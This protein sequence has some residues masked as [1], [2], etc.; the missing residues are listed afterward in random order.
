MV[1]VLI[2]RKETLLKEFVMIAFFSL[3]FA[4]VIYFANSFYIF[5]YLNE[6]EIALS[7][8]DLL[9]LEGLLVMIFGGF[10]LFI[11]GSSGA[12]ARDFPITRYEYKFEIRSTFT[13]NIMR[14]GVIL[15]STGAIL[16]VLCFM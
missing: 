2:M 8:R 16:I 4:T 13:P 6:I 10:F 12:R 5:T 15:I 7:Q 9:F 1:D 14:T 11:G 3:I